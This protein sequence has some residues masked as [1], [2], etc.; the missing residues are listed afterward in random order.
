MTYSINLFHE[1]AVVSKQSL[2]YALGRAGQNGAEGEKTT[3]KR[4]RRLNGAALIL[5][6]IAK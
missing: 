2:H 4:M 5:N 6:I 3:E 1:F